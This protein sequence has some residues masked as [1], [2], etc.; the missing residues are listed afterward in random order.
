MELFAIIFSAFA[1]SICGAL[2]VYYYSKG[3]R[4]YGAFQMFLSLFNLV[5][6]ALNVIK[7]Y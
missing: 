3:Q 5:M 1:F 7:H 2:S 4:G 6:V